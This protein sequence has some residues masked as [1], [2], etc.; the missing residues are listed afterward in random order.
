VPVLSAWL[1]ANW[2][3]SGCCYPPTISAGYDSS[4]RPLPA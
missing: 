3:R 1:A 4:P 2:T